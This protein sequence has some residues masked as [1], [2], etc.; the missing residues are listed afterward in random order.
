MK[1]LICAFIM[2]LCAP[3]LVFASRSALIFV[4]LE[5]ED[6][7][8]PELAEVVTLA[9]LS[10]ILGP[11]YDRLHWL[12]NE[13]ANKDAFFSTLQ[14]MVA[15]ADAVDL[16]LAMHGSMQ[17]FWGHF[18]DRFSVD[19]ILSLGSFPDMGNLRLVYVGSCHGWDLTDEFLESG[20]DSTVG[21]PTTMRNFPFLPLFAD[22][23]AR[24]G[25]TV[26]DSVNASVLYPGEFLING[27][28]RINKNSND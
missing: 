8:S 26:E 10:S 15:E 23:F 14:S 18:N 11:S 27:S 19:D 12:I 25:L 13:D 1:R 3:S 5:H 17:F 7:E 21:S 2:L 28:R 4:E 24:K 6:S 16:Y 20:A 22:A 9:S